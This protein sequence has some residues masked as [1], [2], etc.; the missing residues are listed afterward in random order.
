[1]KVI[2]M[3]GLPGSG[4]STWVAQNTDPKTTVVC[5]AD[6]FLYDADGKYNWTPERLGKAHQACHD[7]F[8][9]WLNHPMDGDN[10]IAPTTIVVDNCNLTNR[11]MRF[12]IEAAEK[13]GAE[14]EIRTIHTEPKV[15]MGRQLHGVPAEKYHLLVQRLTMP[16]R[17][18]WQKYEVKS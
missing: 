4:K 6:N 10:G 9:C 1:M 13:A 14:I 2:I 18:D 7:K 5:S 11:D 3:R 8:I 17:P 12:Y 16:L 15:A